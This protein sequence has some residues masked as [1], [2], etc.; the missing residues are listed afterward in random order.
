MKLISRNNS[1]PYHRLLIYSNNC[2][3]ML[4][5]V[6]GWLILVIFIRNSFRWW[7]M[8]VR[9]CWLRLKSILSATKIL[10]Q[11]FFPM[12]I[13]WNPYSVFSLVENWIYL[14]S[15]TGFCLQPW[16]KNFNWISTLV[17]CISFIKSV[18]NFKFS[19]SLC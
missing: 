13:T 6:G 18:Q 7:S 1:H 10:E 3:R 12:L 11:N 16:F 4:L 8:K 5:A 17:F 2:M 14:N 19:I 9:G 15:S